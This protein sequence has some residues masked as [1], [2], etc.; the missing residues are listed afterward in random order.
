M[1]ILIEDIKFC[2]EKF[3]VNTPINKVILLEDGPG[4]PVSENDIRKIIRLDFIDGSKTVI[5]FVHEERVPASVIDQ[6]CTLSDLLRDN[7]VPAPKRWKI[8]DSYCVKI[9]KD[10]LDLMVYMEEYLPDQISELTIDLFSQVGEMMGKMHEISDKLKPHID[11]SMLYDEVLHRDIPY[12]KLWGKADHSFIRDEDM[13]KLL[14]IYDK[15]IEMLKKIWAELPMGAVQNDIYSCNNFCMY[16]GKI[17]VYDFNLAG[18]EAFIGDALRCWFRTVFDERTQDMVNSL[19]RKAL[20]NGFW[21]GYFKERRLTDI[22]I[23]YFSDIYAILGCA[24]YTKLLVHLIDMGQKEYVVNN[25]DYTFDL[26]NSG[27]EVLPI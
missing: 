2:L 17:A 14:K 19:D 16:N 3:G 18:D 11:F 10:N 7:G 13:A 22:E 12:E 25:W 26:L 23:K 5:K 21:N 15:R 1:E 6:Q 9:I 8:G 20:W 4:R 27:N 24:Y